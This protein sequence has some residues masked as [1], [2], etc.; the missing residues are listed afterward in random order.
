MGRGPGVVWGL[1]LG[2]VEGPIPLPR[3]GQEP[4]SGNQSLVREWISPPLEKSIFSAQVSPELQPPPE[5]SLGN[6]A[7]SSVLRSGYS[8]E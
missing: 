2:A 6:L 8:Q 7:M 3:V 5:G 1:G 4:L